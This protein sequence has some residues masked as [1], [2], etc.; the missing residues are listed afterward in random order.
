[1]PAARVTKEE[2]RYLL[3]YDDGERQLV[4]IPEGCKVTFGAMQMAGG[5]RFGRQGEG[6]T[7]LRVY[8]GG[9]GVQLAIFRNV[10]SFRDLTSLKVEDLAHETNGTGFWKEADPTDVSKEALKS[11]AG[12]NKRSAEF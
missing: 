5:E 4:T 12:K 8:E 6:G 3:C 10:H 7:C 2:K 9:E 1:M 11:L